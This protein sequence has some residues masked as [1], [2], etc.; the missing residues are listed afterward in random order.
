MAAGRRD[1]C[2]E[3]MSKNACL[4]EEITECGVS[5]WDRASEWNVHGAA[6]AEATPV[7]DVSVDH[8]RGDAPVAQELLDGPD[9]VACLEEMGGEGVA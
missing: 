6:D 8:R 3:G 1:C 4:A 7:E 9:V 2:N 5:K